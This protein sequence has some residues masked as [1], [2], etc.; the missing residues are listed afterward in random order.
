MGWLIGVIVG[1]GRGCGSAVG[2]GGSKLKLTLFHEISPFLL[3]LHLSENKARLHTATLPKGMYL[4]LEI[5]IGT[6]VTVVWCFGK[7]PEE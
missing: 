3:R 7:M 1:R 5:N 4:S 6:V 2:L